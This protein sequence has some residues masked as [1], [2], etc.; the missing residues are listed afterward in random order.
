MALDVPFDGSQPVDQ[1]VAQE[2]QYPA[3]Q[4]QGS[5][6]ISAQVGG[7]IIAIA[8]NYGFKGLDLTA[9][10]VLPIVVLKNDIFMVND[11]SLR[12]G[13]EFYCIIYGGE[14]KFVYKTDLGE[15]DPRNDL[16]Y[17]YDEKYI[18]GSGT[19]IQ[20][21]LAEWKKQGLPYL[22]KDYIDVRIGVLRDGYDEPLLALLS[23]PPT[24]KANYTNIV[25][26]LVNWAKGSGYSPS[27]RTVRVFKGP[28]VQKVKHPFY[29]IKFEMMPQ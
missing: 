19:S 21:R 8:E 18:S 29:P 20:T 28:V 1:T 27:D 17:T 10:G 13:E 26:Q 7:D 14:P 22:R 9:F 4:S 11:G 24:S 16:F 25:L 6:A 12:F 3:E 2:E 23:V 15:K 5:H